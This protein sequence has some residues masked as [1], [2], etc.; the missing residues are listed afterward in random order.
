MSDAVGQPPEAARLAR[1]TEDL[2]ASL[3][4]LD[5]AALLRRPA[6]DEWSAWD[7]A[8]HVAQI[9]VW[10]LAKLCEAA[11]AD[12][13]EAMAHFVEAWRSLRATGLALAARIPAGRLDAAGLLGGVSD[14]TPRELL[15]RIADHD[16]E[17][18]EQARRAAR[19]GTN[20]PA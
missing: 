6:A 19:E 9:E 17:H 14:W 18:A 7:I 2:L 3:S 5:A 8:Y 12:A 13:P 1:S 4:D 16:E 11:A 20:E 15:G 10:Y